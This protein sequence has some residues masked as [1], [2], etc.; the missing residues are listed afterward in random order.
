LLQW[1]N[2]YAPQCRGTVCS[3]PSLMIGRSTIAW[4][5]L[6]LDIVKAGKQ[7]C[8]R[9][10]KS[11]H[12][13]LSVWAICSAMRASR[14]ERPFLSHALFRVGLI[15]TTKKQCVNPTALPYWSSRPFPA[16]LLARSRSMIY[17][18][19]RRSPHRQL[20][21]GAQCSSVVLPLQCFR[22]AACG[23]VCRHEILFRKTATS[24]A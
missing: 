2:F 12:G 9:A 19:P 10:R 22:S 16:T 1:M 7:N 17:R 5:W 15:R 11:C 6:G 21:P 13:N 20:L 8:G 24:L 14:S 3:G 23:L 18:I 4:Y